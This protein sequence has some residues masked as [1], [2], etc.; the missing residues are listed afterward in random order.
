VKHLWATPVLRSRY[1]LA[2]LAGALLTASFPTAGIAGLAWV[3]PGLMVA[4]AFGKTRSQAFRIGYVAGLAHY[5]TL[6]YWLLLIPY[7]WHGI[8]LGPAAGWLALSTFLALFPATWVWF[9]APAHGRSGLAD[10]SEQPERSAGL[11]PGP[12]P[13]SWLRRT[14]WALS[15]A[16]IW[17]A[18]EM[19]VTRI[20]G[21]FP[22]AL[23]GVSQYSMVP[24][25]QLASLAGVYGISFIVAWLSLSVVSAALSLIRRPTARSAWLAEVFLPLLA[26]AVLFNL[27]LRQLRQEPTSSRTLKITLIQ[28]SVPQTVIW[29]PDQGAVRFRDVLQLTEQALT[30]Q[31]DLLIWP[32]SAIPTPLRFDPE[33]GGALT[34][35]ALQ[36]GV[37]MIVGADDADPAPGATNLHGA[38]W[39]NS[40][41]L[42]SPRGEL[43]QS[44]RKRN[45]VMFGEYIPLQHALP[46]LGWFTPVDTGFT[47]G[48]G[49]VPF[50]LKELGC[51]TA[52]MICFEDIFPQIGRSD[53]G[54]G[55]DFL[56]NITND[57]WFGQGAA[58]WQQ[59]AS[60][61]FRTVENRVP[62]VRCTN[63]GLTCWVDAFGRMQ[64]VLRD[65]HGSVYGAGFLTI[66]LPVPA[67]ESRM[68]FYNRHGDW[69][70][71]GCVAVTAPILAA[72]IVVQARSTKARPKQNTT[73][74]R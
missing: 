51:Q 28:P 11:Q 39:F 19:L 34:N 4:A 43:V 29:D 35:L 46:F 32:E 59:A 67:E 7:R 47:P 58:Q 55:T 9:V 57:G 70:G 38:K 44:Y 60:A 56:V 69:F 50:E 53:V 25:I 48:E 37:W 8:P 13:S 20:F 61:V 15:G 2:C 68:T 3:A 31:T 10:A 27:G 64:D 24:L 66:D 36:H 73:A 18:L 65:S 40:S 1:L 52:V 49:A 14:V 17:V 63:N 12:L 5:L 26:V 23:L 45:L 71:W 62:L 41:F 16:A 54:Q 33:V 30:N 42:I 72:R 21:G 6:L 74:H 22:W